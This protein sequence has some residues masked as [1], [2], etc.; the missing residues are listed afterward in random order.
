MSKIYINEVDLT[1]VERTSSDGTDI[2]Y[3]PGFSSLA[4]VTNGAEVGV[5]VLCKTIAEFNTAFGT[6]PAVF[7]ETQAYP[8]QFDSYAVPTVGGV[9]SPMFAAGAPDPSYIF[10][11]E[12]LALGIPVL[13]ERV[14]VYANLEDA[15]S[16]EAYDVTVANM[17]N[18]LSK[19]FSQGVDGSGETTVT[20]GTVEV[21]DTNA[22]TAAYPDA[23]TYTFMATAE[24]TGTTTI[25]D[26][27]VTIDNDVY[28]NSYD[29]KYRSTG[30]HIFT[31]AVSNVSCTASC[32][33][34]GAAVSVDAATFRTYYA[35]SGRY[36][37]TYN[38]NAWTDEEDTEVVLATIGI[39]LNI[40]TATLTNG[41]IIT[42]L[43]SYTVTWN[44]NDLQP[45][46]LAEL[47][48]L[49]TGIPVEEST[50]TIT[51]PAID[52]TGVIWKDN[53]GVL[54]SLTQIGITLTGTVLAA[55]TITI[56]LTYVEPDL[57]DKGLYSVKYITSGG[58]PTFEYSGKAISQAM[59]TLAK[60]RGDAIALIDHTNNPDRDLVGI[61][62]VF[63]RAGSAAYALTP[64]TAS[65]GAMFTPYCTYTLINDYS[66]LDT[67][68]FDL[69]PSFAYLSCLAASIASNPAWLAIAGATR[70]KVGNLNSVNTTKAITNSIA[71]SYQPDNKVCINPIT[72]IRPYGQCIWGNRTLVDNSIKQGTTALSYLNIRNLVCDIKKQLFL[73]CQSLLFEQNTDVLWMN[74]LSLVTPLL[75][76]MVSGYG[77]SNYKIIKENPSDKSTITAIIRIYPVYAVESFDLTLYLQ[78]G[79]VEVQ[80]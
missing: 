22:F 5:P 14:N 13:Y 52:P 18:F 49:L 71:D 37:F 57:L 47:G 1:T 6:K 72:N 45:V 25:E 30:A 38:D 58:Y 65:Y 68:L 67:S 40:G 69:P 21:T 66:N 15:G 44:D 26:G 2:V 50:I 76:R 63:N 23:G 56:S 4:N 35:E 3:V 43:T 54:K 39:T 10:A 29:K 74:F 46:T 8:M 51:V 41:S 75:D 11:K 12:L 48:V 59:A 20:G 32:S 7:A 42:I 34:S 28:I 16:I 77:I 9:N 64:I 70:G 60:D 61:R 33:V 62:S 73:A 36:I 78:N 80:E 31:A 27:N 24:C 17:Y 55:D 19:N 79:E 53:Q